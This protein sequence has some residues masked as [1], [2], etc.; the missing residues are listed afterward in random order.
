MQS[1]VFQTNLYAQQDRKSFTPASE[2]EMRCFLGLSLLMGIKRSPSYRDYWSSAPDLHGPFISKLMTVNRF[3]WFLSHLHLNDNVLQPQRGHPDFD[4]LYKVRPLLTELSTTFADNYLPTEFV[5]IDES[6]IK[7]KGRSC[8]KQYMPKKP[9]KCGYKVWMLCAC[10]GYN[11]K[12][13]IYS[14][15][16]ESGVQKE[17]GA[18]VVKNMCQGLAGKYRRVFFDN[19][20]TSYNLLKELR[21]A[22]IYACGT[23]NSNRRHLPKLQA[24]KSMTRGDT[25]YSVSDESLCCFK[26]KDKRTVHLLSNFHDPADEVE[27]DRKNKDGTVCKV[28]CPAALQDYNR[29][30]NFVGK[31]D[32]LKDQYQVDRKSRKWWHRIFFHFLDC[33]VVNAFIIFKELEDSEK[34]TLKDF[35]RSVIA[36]LTAEGQVGCSSKRKSS[37]HQTVQLKKSK[38]YVAPIIR[39]TVQAPA[40]EMHVTEVCK[41]QH[42]S[43]THK[44]NMD[45]RNLQRPTL[46]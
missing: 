16:S 28:P 15:R 34:M 3:G 38:P 5:A 8:L 32:Q 43:A 17:L 4:R 18:Q 41:L 13:E 36:S 6:V 27:V 21:E 20:F 46:P 12:F 31:F 45:V 33:C 10:D 37:T 24:D 7:F 22:D 14:G 42:E 25:D 23:V 26:W 1:V 29:N 19:Y 35:R 30:M 2:Q 40:K 39:V 44:N 9:V 11:L